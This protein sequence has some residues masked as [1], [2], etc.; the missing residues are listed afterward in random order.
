MMALLNAVVGF[1][2]GVA[3]GLIGL[4]GAEL[5][6]PYLVGVL[7]LTAHVAVPINLAISLATIL[8]A[9]PTRLLV[10]HEIELMRFAGETLAIMLGAILAAWYGAGYLKRLSGPALNRLIFV[11]LLLLGAGLLVEAA[12]PMSSAG[13]LPQSTVVRLAAAVLFGLLIGAI[14]SVLGVAGGEVIIP[15]LVFGYG[16]PVKA[17]G[18]LSMLISL[19]TVLAGIVRH[20]RMGSFMDRSALA[21]VV[22]P[23]GAGSILGAIC[24][25]LLAGTVPASIIKV[26]LG[27]LLIWSA[28]KVFARH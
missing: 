24:G 23:M 19:P 16:T 13:L 9:I 8:A 22:A 5:R 20:A 11:L 18:S 4:G 14:S 3:G 10:L 2:V 27:I 7:G 28:W 21:G 15:T 26:M 25:G 17:A 12:V 1:A 6:L